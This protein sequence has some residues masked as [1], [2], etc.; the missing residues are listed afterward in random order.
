[1][2]QP[3]QNPLSP[4]LMLDLQNVDSISGQ[5]QSQSRQQGYIKSLEAAILPVFKKG[6][7][8]GSCL[9]ISEEFLIGTGF[10]WGRSYNVKDV[11]AEVVFHAKVKDISFQI[12]KIKEGGLSSAALDLNPTG[13]SAQMT[14]PAGSSSYGD[15]KLVVHDIT[16]TI[17][18]NNGGVRA[19][20]IGDQNVSSADIYGI[21]ELGTKQEQYKTRA[22]SAKEVIRKLRLL[23]EQDFFQKR[24]AQRKEGFAIA[25]LEKK[26]VNRKSLKRKPQSEVLSKLDKKIAISHLIEMDGN[27]IPVRVNF[28]YE[29]LIR[30]DKF[31]QHQI[32]IQREKDHPIIFD[33]GPNPDLEDPARAHQQGLFYHELAICA[34]KEY[35]KNGNRW[36]RVDI[37]AKALGGNH[38]FL[39]QAEEK[40]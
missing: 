27:K 14:L 39:S 20:R 32:K 5:G 16:P 17:S 30:P 8:S 33:I 38:Y 1:M 15:L 3:F 21:L 10:Y 35:I 12:L 31:R 34:G 11:K 26:A 9:A 29:G 19:L 18:L 36:P 40:E 25:E 6:E 28:N 4:F 37:H 24:E 23:N 13:P 22:E 7:F 2:I